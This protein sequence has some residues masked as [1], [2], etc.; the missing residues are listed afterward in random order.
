[1][2]VAVPAATEVMAILPPVIATVAIAILLEVAPVP[3]KPSVATSLVV[4]L[5]VDEVKPPPLALPLV[6]VPRVIAPSAAT[7]TRIV[8]GLYPAALTVMVA[9]PA[10]TEVMTILPP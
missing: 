3:T 6:I 10:A 2:M 8:A 4:A 9:V 1:V 7:V 5:F